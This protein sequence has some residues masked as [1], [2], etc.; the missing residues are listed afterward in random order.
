MTRSH[1]LEIV[2]SWCS[3]PRRASARVGQ[4]ARGL[5]ALP[6]DWT[7]PFVAW[8]NASELSTV[9]AARE[10]LRE[11][12]RRAEAA[13]LI[14]RSDGPTEARDQGHGISLVINADED[15][16]AGALRDPAVARCAVVQVAVEPAVVGVM[17][18]ERRVSPDVRNW[19]LEG[20]LS[21]AR[22]ELRPMLTDARRC[23]D[24]TASTPAE[25]FE[26]L[27]GVGAFLTTEGAR[28]RVE[29]LWD[30]R[31]VWVV[32]ADTLPDPPGAAQPPGP[33]GGPL[34]SAGRLSG[35]ASFVGIKLSRWR[36][37]ERL[38]WARP[39]TFVVSGERWRR[40]P[41]DVAR[42]LGEAM[43]SQARSAWV[44]RTDVRERPAIEPL[45][46]PTS[47]P[48][49]DPGPLLRFMIDTARHMANA[50]VCG[51]EWAFLAAPLY[52]CQ[53]S[54]WAHAAPDAD[55]VVVDALFGF[56]DGLL[57]LPHDSYEID[58]T[59]RVSAQVR[60]K[61]ACVLPDRDG[62][63]TRRL[64]PPYDW[65]SPLDQNEL[66]KIA[67]LARVLAAEVESPVELMILARIAGKRGAPGLMP[68]YFTLG[69]AGRRPARDVPVGGRDQALIT[70]PADLD[71][72]APSRQPGGLRVDPDRKSLRDASFLRRAGRWA[73][74]HRVPIIFAGS[75]LGHAFH[76]LSQEGAA[77]VVARD[78]THADVRDVRWQPVVVAYGGGLER[79]RV[80]PS[81][82]VRT[83]AATTLAQLVTSGKDRCRAARAVAALLDRRGPRSPALSLFDRLGRV[84]VDGALGASTT[85]AVP[86]FMDEAPRGGDTTTL[87][88]GVLMVRV[89]NGDVSPVEIHLPGGLVSLAPAGP[90]WAAVTVTPAA[91]V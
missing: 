16:L 1:H 79:V 51:D 5:V 25:A 49:A 78:E 89:E 65:Q 13:R 20:E 56:P 29:W 48:A 31:R 61:P 55:A 26:T 72:L 38:G 52:H 14:V 34:P 86:L 17:S 12:I 73:R 37:F 10:A 43:Y 64:P 46:L 9:D 2:A 57:H 66:S 91:P 54:G 30:G 32:Q 69:T 28:R 36:V 22:P 24:L 7:P 75:P 4:K 33:M 19:L 50:G 11:L 23:V 47:L 87:T 8:L 41:M 27:A 82:E 53:A 35:D 60:F 83:A 18:N 76:L 71:A 88:A 62:W 70:S 63:S 80:L 59:G 85:G 40:D 6:E 21:L 84:E 67:A 42:E 81:D 90:G 74:E 45:L 3:T 58:T 77:V 15:A 39:R 44:V 68:F